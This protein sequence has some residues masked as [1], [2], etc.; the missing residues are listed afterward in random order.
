MFCFL[1]AEPADRAE[2]VFGHLNVDKLPTSDEVEHFCSEIWER[3]KCNNEATEWIRKKEEL[4]KEQESQPWRAMMLTRSPTPSKKS[5]NWK[6][7][8]R[9]KVT[10]F[11]LKHLVS[12]HEDM[13]KAYTNITENPEGT[14]E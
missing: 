9:E 13:S 12:I 8:G 1:K 14:P 11:W 10:N 4:L 5:S 2:T 6:S 3:D 7:P